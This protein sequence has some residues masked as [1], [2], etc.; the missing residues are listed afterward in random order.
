MAEIPFLNSD[1]AKAASSF[2]SSLGSGILNTLTN[3]GGAIGST[4]STAANQTGGYLSSLNQSQQQIDTQQTTKKL[5]TPF[6]SPPSGLSTSN[7]LNFNNFSSGLSNLKSP[8]VMGAMSNIGNTIN[9]AGSGTQKLFGDASQIVTRGATQVADTTMNVLGDTAKFATDIGTTAGGVAKTVLWDVPYSLG[10]YTGDIAV[11]A[12]QSTRTQLDNIMSL[13][14]PIS[15][16]Y[17]PSNL[18]SPTNKI[19]TESG[20]IVTW[21]TPEISEMKSFSKEVQLTPFNKV[22]SDMKKELSN[23][24][25][26]KES[27]STPVY[28][29]MVNLPGESQMLVKGLKLENSQNKTESENI[30]DNIFDPKINFTAKNN[31]SNEIAAKYYYIQQEQDKLAKEKKKNLTFR[32][33]NKFVPKMILLNNLR[34][35]LHNPKMYGMVTSK[36]KPIINERIEYLTFS[37]RRLTFELSGHFERKR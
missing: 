1:Y 14:P 26:S 3:T 4:I 10:G 22:D 2:G 11:K 9:Y 35:Q 33:K 5:P 6:I 36:K 27:I 25:I 15:S 20:N 23:N 13:P 28:S 16:T 31:K 18:S 30:T 8:D 17:T 19:I 21:N 37:N 34:N 32:K 24:Y 7:A 29:E 12:G